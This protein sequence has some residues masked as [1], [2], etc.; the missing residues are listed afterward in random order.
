MDDTT[1]VFVLMQLSNSINQIG[2]LYLALY[3]FIIR[4]I[5]Y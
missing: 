4:N 3:S 2:M 1:S 5:T